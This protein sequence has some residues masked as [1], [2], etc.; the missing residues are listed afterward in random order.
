MPRESIYDGLTYE[1]FAHLR[2]IAKQN[3]QLTAENE[4]LARQLHGEK[5]AKEDSE[6][7]RAENKAFENMIRGCQAIRHTDR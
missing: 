1:E 7:V 2:E 3:L 5:P 4:E 6:Q